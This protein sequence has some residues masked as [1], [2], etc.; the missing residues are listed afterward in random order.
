MKLC[1]VFLIM[2]IA[3][4][5]AGSPI[6]RKLVDGFKEYK[7]K[8]PLGK[9]VKNVHE[10]WTDPEKEPWTLPG[11]VAKKA[12]QNLHDPNYKP[13]TIPGAMIKAAHDKLHDPDYKPCPI[14]GTA[15]KYVH[16]EFD[17]LMAPPKKPENIT[18]EREVFDLPIARMFTT[19]WNRN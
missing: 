19:D 10:N 1:V 11:R 9:L 3:T 18:A 15:V 5:A 12:L 7:P 4:I 13:S 2:A 8:T 6:V 17:N 14:V 16:D